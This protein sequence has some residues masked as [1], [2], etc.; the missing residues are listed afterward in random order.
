[1][2]RSV[3]PLCASRRRC[4][5]RRSDGSL[6]F[7]NNSISLFPIFL[8]AFGFLLGQR[9]HV[10][11]RTPPPPRLIYLCK[12]LLICMSYR[13]GRSAEQMMLCCREL[14]DPHQA[15]DMF[16]LQTTLPVTMTT[17]RNF[18][19]STS[20]ECFSTQIQPPP[21]LPSAASPRPLAPSVRVWGT[22]FN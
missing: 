6:H 14:L 20:P 10:C 7:R 19:S 8:R 4:Y 13:V 16:L 17:N 5:R 22:L 2:E 11:S 15:R 21:P 12:P 9:S 1:M 3:F 18:P